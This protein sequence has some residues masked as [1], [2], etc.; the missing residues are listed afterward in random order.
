LDQA[1]LR[2]QANVTSAASASGPRRTFILKGEL[3]V[4][5]DGRRECNVNRY[6]RLFTNRHTGE[7]FSSFW[8]QVPNGIPYLPYA[9]AAF[10]SALRNAQGHGDK[11]PRS[12]ILSAIE[13]ILEV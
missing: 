10:L 1:R 5:E 11:Y 8:E 4:E 2:E 3:I 13:E 12:H 6:H 9:S 7:L